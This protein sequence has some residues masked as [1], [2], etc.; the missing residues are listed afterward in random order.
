MSINAHQNETEKL[1]DRTQIGAGASSGMQVGALK[2]GQFGAFL[3]C[4][5]GTVR[6]PL[7]FPRRVASGRAGRAAR[8]HH[9]Q[10]GRLARAA[11]EKA[12]WIGGGPKWGTLRSSAPRHL[13]GAAINPSL[14][15]FLN[16]GVEHSTP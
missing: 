1:L 5:R 3:S 9:H 15:V 6:D 12:V 16:Y 11:L 13:T 8:E 14:R 4:V 2:Y 7:A 10:R